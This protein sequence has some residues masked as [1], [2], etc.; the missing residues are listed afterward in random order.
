MAWMKVAK[1][2]GIPSG[3]MRGYEVAGKKVAVA[4]VGDR[5]YAFEDRCTHAGGKLSKGLLMGGHV[6]CPLH[7]A[8]FDVATGKVVAAPATAPVSTYPVKVEGD[9]VLVDLPS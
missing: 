3:F 2:G 4:N 6:M 5:L 9:D 1:V 7:A 8:A